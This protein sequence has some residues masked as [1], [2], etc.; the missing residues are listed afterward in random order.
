MPVG[1]EDKRP[2]RLGFDEQHRELTRLVD[3]LNVSAVVRSKPPVPSQTNGHATLWSSASSRETSPAH[4]GVSTGLSEIRA[5]EQ[6]GKMYQTEREFSQHSHKDLFL[7]LMQALINQR[8]SNKEWL[9]KSESDGVLLALACLRML[10]RDAAF[11][12][13]FF[14]MGG[15]KGVAELLA[16]LTGLYL[17]SVEKPCLVDQLKEL[18]NICQ[19]LTTNVSKREWLVACGI[20]KSLVLLLSSGDVYILHCSLVA[21][22]NLASSNQS[23][24]VI[25]D[26]NCIEVLLRI[27]QDYDIVSKRL[28]SDLL[29]RLCAEEQV[30][31]QVRVF[32]G[33]PICLS[34]LHMEDVLLL[35]N[36]VGIVEWLAFDV[37][38]RDDIRLIGGIPLLISLLQRDC[39]YARPSSSSFVVSARPLRTPQQVTSG[40]IPEDDKQSVWNFHVKAASCSALTVLVKSDTNAQ[41]I[42]S[43]NGVYVI[44]LYIL[45]HMT[46]TFEESVAAMNLQN[47]AFRALRFLFCKERNRRLFKQLFPP[48][49]FEMFIDVGHYNLELSAYERM[50]QRINIMQEN[51]LQDVRNNINAINQLKAPMHRVRKYDVMEHLGS[52]AF[53][54]V[55]KV[56]TKSR[57]SHFKP[58]E[59][60]YYAMKELNKHSPAFGKTQKERETSVGEIIAEVSIM[61]EKLRHP[62]V[63]RYYSAFTESDKLYVVMELIDGAPLM[64]HFSSQKEK[65]ECFSEERIWNIFVQIVLALRYLHKEKRIVHRDLTPGNIMLGE[66]DKVTITDFGLAKQKPDTSVMVSVVGTVLYHCPELIQGVPYSEKADVW[67]AGC[68]LHQMAALEPPFNAQNVLALAKKIAEVDYKP[69]PVGLYSSRISETVARCLT[70]E[71][72]LRPDIVGLAGSIVDILMLHID[73]LSAQQTKTERRLEQ[74]RMRVQLHKD[75][76]TYHRQRFER[77]FHVSQE[78]SDR[79]LHTGSTISSSNQ[80]QDSTNQLIDEGHLRHHEVGSSTIVSPPCELATSSEGEEGDVAG[81]SRDDR[82][83]SSGKSTDSV[84]DNLL[85]S[86]GSLSQDAGD[87]TSEANRYAKATSPPSVSLPRLKRLSATK[88]GKEGLKEKDE[89]A[90][91]FTYGTS[92]PSSDSP[93]SKLGNFVPHPPTRSKSGGARRLHQLDSLSSMGA[94]GRVHHNM[95]APVL[96]SPVAATQGVGPVPSRRRRTLSNSSGVESIGSRKSSA[97]SPGIAATLTIS[98]RKVRQISDPVQQILNQ[99]HKIIFISQ[100]PPS[101]ELSPGRRIIDKFKREIFSSQSTPVYLKSVLKKLVSGSKEVVD[102]SFGF[103]GPVLTARI[104]EIEA[105]AS[106]LEVA[107]D[108]AASNAL[109]SSSMIFDSSSGGSI[110]ITYEQLQVVIESVLVDCGYYDMPSQPGYKM[111]PLAPIGSQG[112]SRSSSSS[113]SNSATRTKRLS[114]M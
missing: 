1:S 20:H 73:K 33:I 25:G 44:A 22:T 3:I 36:M 6:F 112:S 39:L 61:Q 76:S 94:S 69:I 72:D 40:Q 91:K 31:E 60:K 19:K 34:L 51:E 110:G 65:K 26:L 70:A 114:N 92:P 28:A 59:H 58:D 17:S 101:L 2:S 97:A 66:N 90:R 89:A 16:S 95:P 43:A 57:E 83:A 87:E 11:L 55:Y 85:L 79:S 80:R 88:L 50:T 109:L 96:D 104:F 23:R 78:R 98:H 35:L 32:D 9:E 42:V 71:P 81:N 56:K 100:L 47:T 111:A 48:D 99:L 103:G 74:E 24:G 5:F 18:T 10:L 41:H 7:Q 105:T 27:L 53:G 75:D 12:L 13:E 67:A 106:T 86:G 82:L 62:N 15:V 63:V 52:G 49:L 113:T 68:I 45:P 107:G 46:T 4:S 108:H 30:R 29:K 102:L 8:L 37:D 54:S 77:L 84:F 93:Q 21:L 38:S 14:S 64:E